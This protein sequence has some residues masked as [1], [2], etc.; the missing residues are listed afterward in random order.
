MVRAR[1]PRL[2]AARISAGV[3]PIS[4]SV[5]RKPRASPATTRQLRTL[6]PPGMIASNSAVHIATV[7]TKMLAIPE[8]MYCSDHTTN[9]LPPAS[10]S[11]PTM[12]RVRQSVR[13]GNGSPRTRAM[14]ARINPAT[15]N[16]SPAKRNGGSSVTPTLM[17]R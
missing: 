14:V 10:S 9:A 8:P 16:R 1:G 11:T 15:M 4:N 6:C 2:S 17:A 7:T 5:P 12:A 3:A 13:R